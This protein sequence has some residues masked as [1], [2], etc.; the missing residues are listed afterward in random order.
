MIVIILFTYFAIGS[1]LTVLTIIN[2]YKEHAEL[3]SR[4]FIFDTSGTPIPML[5]VL[6][7]T[8]IIW[9]LSLYI[10]YVLYEI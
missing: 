5:Y 3:S 10:Y 8:I 7:G 9:P 6:I 2:A 4:H 1:I